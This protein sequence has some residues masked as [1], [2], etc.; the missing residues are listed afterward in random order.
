MISKGRTS[1][2]I[3]R[4]LNMGKGPITHLAPFFFGGVRPRT[5]R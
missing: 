1:L 4:G 2:K 3:E 5:S